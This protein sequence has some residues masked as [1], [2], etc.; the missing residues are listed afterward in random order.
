[1]IRMALLNEINQI[2]SATN[3]LE[4]SEFVVNTSKNNDKYILQIQ[5]RFDPLYKFISWIPNQKSKDKDSYSA[6]FRISA[7][8][9]PGEISETENVT[10]V[11][12]NEL[13]NGIKE[14]LIR[15]RDELLAAP[16]H[17]QTV[18]Q[19]EQIEDILT[20]LPNFDDEY[21][22]QEEIEKFKKNLEELEERLAENIR[23]AV[24]DQ[25]EQ[26]V[27]IEKLES[28]INLLKAKL[29]SHKKRAWA[30][31]VGTRL[32]QWAQDPINRKVLKSGEQATKT[33][34]LPAGDNTSETSENANDAS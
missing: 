13:F 30:G 4:P 14:W 5:Y 33:L 34:L 21:F 9:S 6:D 32:I 18:E 17:R 1:M 15:V 25:K 2:I 8:I 12:K 10:Y 24:T 23:N 7:Q 22:S 28:E 11:G 27:R 20:Q 16:T 3:Y 29:S 19:K 31:N 26:K